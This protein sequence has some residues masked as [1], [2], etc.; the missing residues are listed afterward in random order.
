MTLGNWK[1]SKRVALWWVGV[2]DW[3]KS[4]RMSRSNLIRFSLWWALNWFQIQFVSHY[5][6]FFL[7]MEDSKIKNCFSSEFT[8]FLFAGMANHPQESIDF[9]FSSSIKAHRNRQQ[10]FRFLNFQS[11]IRLR[12]EWKL[13]VIKRKI[14]YEHIQQKKK[15]SE[16]RTR[17][18]ERDRLTSLYCCNN[19]SQQQRENNMPKNTPICRTD[20]LPIIRSRG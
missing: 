11:F 2:W 5:C 15:E 1:E 8:W 6:Y 12:L 19:K 7:R 9:R 10:Q 20:Y 17:K 13:R 4:N 14:V 16:N 3:M 18:A